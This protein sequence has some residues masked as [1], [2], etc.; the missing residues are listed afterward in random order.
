MLAFPHREPVG[1]P[2]VPPEDPAWPGEP[3]PDEPKPGSDRPPYDPDRIPGTPQAPNPSSP[4][5]ID[6]A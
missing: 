2:D 5:T 1:P 6:L 4:D 3:R